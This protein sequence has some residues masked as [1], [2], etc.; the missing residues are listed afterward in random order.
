MFET[1]KILRFI[2]ALFIIGS[3]TSCVELFD[4]KTDAFE[5]TLVIDALLTTELKQ[6]KVTLFRT[7]TFE[8]EGPATEIGSLVE[9]MDNTGNTYRFKESEP[10]V[11]LSE[12]PFAA[13]LE[14][15]YTLNVQTNDGKSYRSST[16]TT[17]ENI[18]IEEI[19]AK[20]LVND[21]GEEGISILLDNNASPGKPRYF[22]YEYE[23]TYKI[24]A[25]KY[26]PFEFEIIDY[27]PCDG[28]FYEVGIKPRTEEQRVCFGSALSTQLIQA[29]TVSLS[30][31]IVDDFVI[32]FISRDNYIMSHR[33]SIMVRQ[34][35][36]TQDAYSYYERL[37]DFSSSD[38][39]FSQVQPGFLEGNIAS[40]TGQEDKVLGYFE[41]AAIN[42]KR[43]YFNY[44]D[45]F[46][47]EALPPYAVNCETVRNP[48]LITRGYHCDGS[49]CDGAC[50]SPL[51][52]AILAGIVV[53]HSE[54]ENLT[55]NNPGPYFTLPSPCGDCTKLGSN[56]VP[57]F[58]EE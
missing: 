38:N 49:V 29:S 44:T 34:Y 27:T 3:S 22:R 57:D 6:H 54:N 24:I 9:I 11:Y 13:Q 32:R 15:G 45:L 19:T 21:K 28:N 46:Q 14:T 23:E 43:T 8:A 51:I 37:G 12:T 50:E 53:F 1:Y 4:A 52:E 18:P 16:V 47:G 40:G 5:N 17:P 31:N 36:Q 42:E 30:N 35:S 10:G 26:D 48:E 33:Y 56:I 25:P 41:V 20:R 58:W 55:P 39:V 2:S 7:Y